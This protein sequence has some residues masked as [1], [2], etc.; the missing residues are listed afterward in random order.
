MR[1]LSTL[2]FKYFQITTHKNSFIK[3]K[4]TIYS[5]NNKSKIKKITNITTPSKHKT[6]KSYLN[7]MIFQSMN[8]LSKKY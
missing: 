4:N 8:N 1:K 2:M 7:K 5:Q 6:I 3:E